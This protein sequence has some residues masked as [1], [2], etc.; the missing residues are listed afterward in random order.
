MIRRDHP[1]TIVPV[2]DDGFVYQSFSANTA[3][4]QDMSI[5]GVHFRRNWSSPEDIGWKCLAVNLSD[6]ASLGAKPNFAQVSL[7]VPKNT[8]D[9]DILGFY[10]GMLKLADQ[11]KMEIVGGDLCSSPGPWIVDVS[12][13]GEVSHPLGRSRAES[14]D[15][16]YVTGSLGLSSLGLSLLQ[17]SD[18]KIISIE[19]T[20][21]DKK[22]DSLSFDK[23]ESDNFQKSKAV[24]KHRR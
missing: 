16:V 17:K 7:A 14:G 5:E 8:K 15:E 18:E 13:I 24:T 20:S 23:I 2:G 12:C 1:K 22:T 3:I 9:E 21:N 4:V 6:L 11:W 10:R 19:N